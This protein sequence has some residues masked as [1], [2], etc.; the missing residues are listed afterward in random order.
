MQTGSRRVEIEGAGVELRGC[1]AFCIPMKTLQISTLCTI[2][3]FISRAQ[4]VRKHPVL[5]RGC[6]YGFAPSIY[7]LPSCEDL[8]LMVLS[9]SVVKDHILKELLL[10]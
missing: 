4:S 3:S 7:S 1:F 6:P 2:R 10:V 9:L 5:L 8:C